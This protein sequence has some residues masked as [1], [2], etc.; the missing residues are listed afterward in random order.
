MKCRL[1]TTSAGRLSKALTILLLGIIPA[2]AETVVVTAYQGTNYPAD[3]TPCPP[4][5][6]TG[7]VSEFGSSSYSTALSS[8]VR[9]SRFGYGTNA[10]WSVT[11]TLGSSS[12]VYQI[13]VT[14]P[15][16]S[17]SSDLVVSLTV[18]NAD[19]GPSVDGAGPLQVTAFRSSFTANTWHLIGYLTNHTSNPSIT[20]R[21][22]SG[23]IDNT[24]QRWYMDAV[25]FQ[26]VCCCPFIPQAGI[27]EPL[28]AGQI[29]VVA[30]NIVSGATN[31]TVYANGTSI[32]ST[33]NPS[34]FAAGQTVVPTATLVQ[35]DMI[36]ALQWKEGC[37]SLLPVSGPI[38]GPL[39]ITTPF[40]GATGVWGRAASLLL[41]ATGTKP[42]NYQWFKD[43]NAIVSATNSILTLP[44][45]QPGDAGFYS[46]IVSNT[47][48]SLT[49]GGR[50]LIKPADIQ[51]Q[52][53]AEHNVAIGIDGVAG[54]TYQIQYA[55]DVGHTNAWTILTNLA[56]VQ[57][58]TSWTDT[59]NSVT[60]QSLFYRILPAP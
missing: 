60:N 52:V 29:S 33:N 42:L 46:V 23:N 15:S 53:D 28:A 22:E 49:N 5:C 35:G 55:T 25:R 59:V 39:L 7:A 1:N 48:L 38:V 31:V 16:A 11:P 4:S 3:L 17:S 9:R 40:T 12:S 50:L 37:A 13:Y 24:G 2:M 58:L 57:S 45:V 56:L 32:G 47:S 41:E 14:R 43:T 51:L 34:G 10:T 30:T 8:P 54:Y 20:F 19:L 26:G 21:Y 36:T 27:R 44:S 6:T 18:T